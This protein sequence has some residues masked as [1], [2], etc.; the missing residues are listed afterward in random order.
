LFTQIDQA[1]ASGAA[2]HRDRLSGQV[3]LFG[4]LELAPAAKRNG[5]AAEFTPWSLSEKLAFEKEL[6]GFYVTGH[7]LDAYRDLLEGGKYSPITELPNL[8]DKSQ[9]KVAGSISGLE[10][11]FTR[12]EGKPFAVVM[13]ED[14]TGTVEIL[15]WADIY[16]RF[17]KELEAGKIVAISAKLE[18][19]DDTVRLIASE[20]GPVAKGKKGGALTIDI[21]L[22][23]TNEDK[24]LALREL[25][26][27]HPGPQPLFLRFRAPDGQELRVK[28]NTGYSV[29]DDASFREELAQLLG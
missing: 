20:I 27:K 8:E 10:K 14:F 28:T 12:K 18:R 5:R 21:L 13:L 17:G 4:D 3:S 6:L 23:R 7:P 9:V 29:H 11:K 19:R 26:M 1:L 22:E 16:A 2:L 25:V 15:V 24:L